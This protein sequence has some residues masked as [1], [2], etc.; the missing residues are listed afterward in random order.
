MG[1][2][3]E[4]ADE[5]IQFSDAERE[6]WRNPAPAR[7][8]FDLSLPWL[9]AIVGCAIFISHP[10]IW[11]WLVAVLFISGA[12]HGL[13]LVSHEAVHRLV[14]PADKRVNDFIATYFFAAPSVLPFNVYRQR[15]LLHH[16][17]VS[18][19]GDTK[20]YYLRD[21]S[22]LRLFWEIIRSVTG[23]DYVVQA[24]GALESGKD[25][26]QYDKFE[27]NLAKDKRSLVITHLV[28]LGVFTAF[29]PLHFGIPTYYFILWLGPMLTTSLLF[30]K[31]RSIVEH[32]PPPSG[33]DAQT[34]TEY[35]KN[36]PGPMLRSVRATWLERFFLSKINF[37]YH[38]EHHLWPWI[39]YQHLP[40]V[41]RRLWQDR[42]LGTLRKINGNVVVC[43]RGYLSVIWRLMRAE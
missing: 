14:W 42:E 4:I 26:A 32:Q 15:H 7:L 13:S 17:L 5:T 27:E 16:R 28:L 35:F 30:G 23:I 3:V 29:D 19:V 9:Q 39:S 41:N 11:T 24:T 20:S 38:G 43:D 37:H 18:R 40:E 21:L 8:I 34:E 36:T 2:D 10:A 12:Q 6:A 31:L 1:P 33:Y 25:D 22:G